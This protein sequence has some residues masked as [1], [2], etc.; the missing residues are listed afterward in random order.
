MRF[1]LLGSGSKGNA[2]YIEGGGSAILIDAGFS[3]RELEMRMQG[4]ERSL[5]GVAGI[6][7]THEHDDHICGAGVVSRR[8]KVPLHANAGT[9]RGGERRLGRPH[10]VHEFA[11]GDEILCGGLSVRSFPVSHDTLDPVGFI[12]S[13]GRHRLGYC[14]DTGKVTH[15]IERRLGGCEAL[16]VEFNHNLDMLRNGP[17]PLPLQQRVRSVTGHLSNEQG[18]EALARLIADH[19]QVA[20]LAHLSETNNTPALARGAALAAVAEWGDTAL[21]IAEQHRP[22]ELIE[23]R[24]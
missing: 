10:K 7:L 24:H 13:D 11:T 21:V 2:V 9:L 18:A 12:V 22:L 14:T 6:F 8:Y 4:I 16:I 23:L 20:V 5:A 19:L 3:G 17:Y 15:L 1:S